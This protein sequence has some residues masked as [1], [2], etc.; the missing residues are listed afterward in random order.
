MRPPSRLRFSP[1]NDSSNHQF[2]TTS[3]DQD[4]GPTTWAK[5]ISQIRQVEAENSRTLNPNIINLQLSVNEWIQPRYEFV[6][7]SF[8]GVNFQ[9]LK[10]D[11]IAVSFEPHLGC[12]HM[13]IGWSFHCEPRRQG[14]TTKSAGHDMRCWQGDRRHTSQLPFLLGGRSLDCWSSSS[15]FLS[16]LSYHQ[17][18]PLTRRITASHAA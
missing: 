5:V 2:W 12:N 6:T 4:G 9:P 7:N 18:A 17:N 13:A 15:C 1:R 8:R 14:V 10:S 3:R 11:W 16:Y